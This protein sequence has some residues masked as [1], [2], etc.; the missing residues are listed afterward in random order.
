MYIHQLSLTNQ[1]IR[2]ALQQY[3]SNT[4]AQTVL[5]LVHGDQKK[6][7]QLATWFRNVAEK[8]KEGVDINA[9]IAIMRMWQIGNADIKDL[10]EEGSP[11]FVLTYSGSQIV[12][13]VP[14][15]KLFQAL[16]FD[17]EVKSA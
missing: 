4:V 11:I 2:N 3:D 6:A 8:C 13:Q 17:S 9:D 12:K 5:L 10:D 1:R 16:L 7:D 14:K 15:E